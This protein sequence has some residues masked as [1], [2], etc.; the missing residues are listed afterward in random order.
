MAHKTVL[1]DD[2]DGSEEDVRTVKFSH[3]GD[4]HT[5]DLG[6]KNREKLRAALD[7][8]IVKAPLD[9]RRATEERSR[10]IREWAK[11]NGYALSPAG[12]IPITV[13]KA[14]EEAQGGE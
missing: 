6:P 4:S 12:R 11:Q 1:I 8:F 7:P 5:I 9:G 2:L 3:D 10:I 13:L 14:F